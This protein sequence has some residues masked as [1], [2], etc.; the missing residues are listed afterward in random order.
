LNIKIEVENI[1]KLQEQLG[2]YAGQ[3]EA[4]ARKA[5][6]KTAYDI[7]REA[8]KHCPVSPH[9]GRLRSSIAVEVGKGASAVIG[10]NVKYAKYV[11]F[12]TKPHIIRVK[13]AKVLTD[14]KT[15]FGKEVHHPGTKPEPFLRPAFITQV[16]NL[17]RYLKEE[18]GK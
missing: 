14:G 2:K 7:H 8:V 13:N 9:G 6:I 5:V 12:G 11:E 17:A 15:F 16:V 4:K 3:S 18:F 1:K 10:T